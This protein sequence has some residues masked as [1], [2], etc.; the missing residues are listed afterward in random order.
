MKRSFKPLTYSCIYVAAFLL[1]YH[2][3]EQPRQSPGLAHSHAAV[4]LWISGHLRHRW[5]H[6]RRAHAGFHGSRGETS[7]ERAVVSAL[8]FTLRLGVSWQMV[9][10]LL[11]S[12][13]EETRNDQRCKQPFPVLE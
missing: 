8:L 2:P 10:F 1:S 9:G 6:P 7:F 5:L 3:H 12:R 13:K 11:V 4:L